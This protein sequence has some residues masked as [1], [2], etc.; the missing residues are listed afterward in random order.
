VENIW[1]NSSSDYAGGLIGYVYWDTIFGSVSISNNYSRSPVYAANATYEGGLIGDSTGSSIFYYSNYWSTSRGD[2][3]Q[4]ACSVGSLCGSPPS[5][6]T[7]LTDDQ[8]KNASSFTDWS[9]DYWS[10]SADGFPRL[11]NVA[12]WQ[13]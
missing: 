5:G 2:I 4:G 9:A 11:K 10:F 7:P 8:M 13:W 3:T 12:H 6:I 1:L